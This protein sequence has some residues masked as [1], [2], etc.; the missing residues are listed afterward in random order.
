MI[1]LLYSIHS[2]AFK[3]YKKKN[4]DRMNYYNDWKD[5]LLIEA[6]SHFLLET[7]KRI[8]LKEHEG[9]RSNTCHL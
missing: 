3:I 5:F 9:I 6:V 2:D 8:G 1:Q 4:S 7:M